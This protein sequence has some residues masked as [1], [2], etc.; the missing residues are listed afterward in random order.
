[1]NRFAIPIIVTILCFNT[2]IISAQEKENNVFGENDFTDYLFAFSL[3]ESA[4]GAIT[5]F[6]LIKPG[7]SVRRKVKHITLEDFLYQASGKMQSVANPTK[8]NFFKEYTI[9]RPEVVVNELWKLRYR[10]FPY[11]MSNEEGW[12]A[13]DTT[14]FLPSESQMQILKK[15]GMTRMGDYVVGENAFKLLKNMEDSTWINNYK[16]GVE[17]N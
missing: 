7:S 13:G 10:S 5:H 16:M 8:K 12:S 17:G 15:Y 6:A 3:T 14:F 4:S 9:K 2:L 1:M 11:G